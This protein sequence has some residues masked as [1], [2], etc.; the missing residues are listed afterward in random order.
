MEERLIKAINYFRTKCRNSSG[1]IAR[2]TYNKVTSSVLHK[3]S[4]SSCFMAY[5]AFVT[6]SQFF[7]KVIV[8][9]TESLLFGKYNNCAKTK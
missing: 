6:S 1:K 3:E 7:L 8:N 2:Q 5:V 9:S 4:L